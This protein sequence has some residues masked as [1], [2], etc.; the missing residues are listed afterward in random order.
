MKKVHASHYRPHDLVQCQGCDWDFDGH[1]HTKKETL[2]KIREHVTSTGHTV[3]RE[4]GDTTHYN[5][6]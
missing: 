1:H 5:Y 6:F 3:H 2:S 4:V